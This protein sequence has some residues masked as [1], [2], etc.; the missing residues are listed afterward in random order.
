MQTL[1]DTEAAI[2][3]IERLRW[4]HYGLKEAAVLDRFGMSMTRYF[5]VL[6]ALID[7][8][9]ALA[10]EPG[11]VRRLVRLREARRAVR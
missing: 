6:N 4:K 9:E 11:L 5:Q 3:A 2:L 8:P 7:R 10:A 1:T